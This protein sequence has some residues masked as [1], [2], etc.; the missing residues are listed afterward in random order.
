MNSIGSVQHLELNMSNRCR[1]V[2][3]YDFG[4]NLEEPNQWKA[5]KHGVQI[6]LSKPNK[7]NYL[8]NDKKLSIMS[9]N[10]LSLNNG[11]TVI[12][13]VAHSFINCNPVVGLGLT[14]IYFF[15]GGW[16]FVWALERHIGPNDLFLIF[17][18]HNGLLFGLRCLDNSVTSWSRAYV[19]Y[20][21]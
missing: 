6:Q 14:R 5:E 19:S 11:E 21:S 17:I 2:E 10:N 3:K 8:L 1:H 18:E 7:L 4:A 16:F 9:T 15:G 20:Y 12:T 13:A